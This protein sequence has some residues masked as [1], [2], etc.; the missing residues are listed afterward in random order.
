MALNSFVIIATIL[1]SAVLSENF[2]SYYVSIQNASTRSHLCNG[3]IYKN[4]YV[5]TA[6]KCIRDL[7]PSDLTVFYGSSQLADVNGTTANVRKIF[8]HPSFNESLDW[9]DLA[10]L[11]IRGIF[12]APSIQ[13]PM[14]DV[15]L[16]E[17]LVHS[18][19]QIV[20][21]LFWFWCFKTQ[22]IA[23]LFNYKKSVN[24]FL[25]ICLTALLEWNRIG[26]T[27]TRTSNANT[28]K[29][30]PT[31]ISSACKFNAKLDDLC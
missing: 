24:Y 14:R 16:N 21:V 20:N 19:W 7:E 13:L 2:V 1:V 3:V 27:A 26:Y 30:M 9:Y 17:S 22:L 8:V 10:I 4:Y 28:Y 29:T 11:R 25:S 31:I 5:L 15:P 18:G 23:I 12:N 6:A